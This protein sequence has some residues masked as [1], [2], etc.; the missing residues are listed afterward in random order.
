MLRHG[1]ADPL[2]RRSR[3]VAAASR[4][5]PEE[6]EVLTDPAAIAEAMA[7]VEPAPA[8]PVEPVYELVTSGAGQVRT[9]QMA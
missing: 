9:R 6:L 4:A 7:D 1:A 8:E 5:F 3:Q 2:V